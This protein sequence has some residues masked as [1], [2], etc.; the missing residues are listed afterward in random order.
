MPYLL[1][2]KNL[3]IHIDAPEENYQNT[4]FDWTGKI[5][6][7]KF[8]NISFASREQKNHQNEHTFGKGFYNEFGID[9]PLG[10]EEAAIGGWFHKIGVGALKKTNKKYRFDENYE[11]QP[12]TFKIK[13]ASNK[14][15]LTCQ[16]TIINGYGYCLEKTIEVTDNG[17]T[18][19]YNLENTGEKTIITDEYVH[20][21]TAI[22][23][24]L[25]GRNYLLK[26]PFQLQ[27]ALFGETVNPAQKVVI[28]QK[29]IRFNSTPTE[30]F[31]FSQLSGGKT[32]AA[33][34]EL[35]HLEHKVGIR[36]SGNFRTNKVNLWG[37]EHVISPELFFSIH[38]Q[39]HQSTKWSR[40]YKIFRIK[41][42]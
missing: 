27:P 37:W 9:T 32:V 20:N 2:N 19:H 18:I 10:F 41:E 15:M 1:K 7:V 42:G 35:I 6:E 31:F 39:P 11:T 21:F 4:R 16:S 8:Q 3:E 30:P 25:I 29:E 36:E 5:V 28:G 12:A 13:E 17:F 23:K 24:E 22:K 26:F 34:W 40:Q 38:I 14:L 33:A